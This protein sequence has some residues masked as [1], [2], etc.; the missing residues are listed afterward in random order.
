MS[1]PDEGLEAPATPDAPPPTPHRPPYWLSGVLGLAVLAGLGAELW[2]SQYVVASQAQV[3][4]EL[5]RMAPLRAGVV[6][7]VLV[8]EGEALKP[9]QVV[10]TLDDREAKANLRKAQALVAA[11][12]AR[13]AAAGGDLKLQEAQSRLVAAQAQAQLRQAEA[14]HRVAL[15]AQAQAQANHGR[16][17]GLA[18]QGIV[19]AMELDAARQAILQA[20]GQVRQSGAQLQEARATVVHAASSTAQEEVRREGQSLE[21]AQLAQAEADLALA[22]QQLE[23]CQVRAKLP[24]L[25]VRRLKAPGE[26]VAAGEALLSYMGQQELWVEGSVGEAE[27]ERLR[28]GAK[29]TVRVDALPQQRFEGQLSYLAIAT[30]EA[31]NPLAPSPSPGATRLLGQVPFRVRLGSSLPGLRPGLHA[32]VRLDASAPLK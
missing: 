12:R 3:M 23:A 25:V 4:G 29:A 31:A 14:A 10:A 16:L 11:A 22:T 18:R 20:Q 7:Q 28:L 32:V 19:S 27:A 15:G 30:A 8:Q 2:S 5:N 17:A 21:A 26:G 6:A 9:G 1:A 13:L 24:G